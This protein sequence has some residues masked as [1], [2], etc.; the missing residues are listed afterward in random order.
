MKALF[1]LIMTKSVGKKKFPTQ[2]IMSS[3]MPIGSLTDPSANFNE[4]L[5][6][7]RFSIPN[8]SKTDLDMRLT[9]ALRSHKAFSNL[10]SPKK[11]GMVKLP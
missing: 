1:I 9:L 8:I 4:I 2:M 7:F 5:V 11:H 3:R 10:I 6:D